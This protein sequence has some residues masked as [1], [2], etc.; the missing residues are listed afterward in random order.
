MEK[1]F[2][3]ITRERKFW[4]EY[5]IRTLIRKFFEV[6]EN[7]WRILKRLTEHHLWYYR[8]DSSEPELSPGIHIDY[9]FAGASEELEDV[10]EEV[11]D[12]GAAADA[13]AASV[14]TEA[15]SAFSFAAV[16]FSAASIFGV[17]S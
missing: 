10:S 8:G 6:S 14:E 9:P 7:E 2:T 3:G 1:V 16:S 17:A 15:S 11:S 4:R 5:N 12:A 13:G